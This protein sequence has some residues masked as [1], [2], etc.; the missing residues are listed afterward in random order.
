[1]INFSNYIK[2]N[3]EHDLLKEKY[4]NDEIFQIGTK[5][6]FG[7][8]VGEIIRRGPNYIIALDESNNVFRSWITDI[9]EYVE[10][11]PKRLNKYRNYNHLRDT[12]DSVQS[13]AI[14]LGM[15]PEHSYK[16]RRAVE[17]TIL[18][19]MEY[20]TA[21]NFIQ[22]ELKSN[23]LVNKAVEYYDAVLSEKQN[24]QVMAAKRQIEAAKEKV[25]KQKVDQQLQIQNQKSNQLNI[26]MR[27]KLQQQAKK[28]ASME[29]EQELDEL[30]ITGNLQS[31]QKPGKRAK[32][33]ELLKK[34]KGDTSKP[35][36][37]WF[38]E[39]DEDLDENSLVNLRADKKRQ[40][41]PNILRTL[42]TPL[43][44]KL[45]KE[46][47][48]VSEEDPC[49]KGYT[50]VGMKDMD[51]REVPN[52]VPSKGVKKARGYKAE[53]LKGNQDRIDANKNGKIDAKDFPL[54]R[55]RKNINK[56]ETCGD[57]ASGFGANGMSKED[58]KKKTRR[59]NFSNWRDEVN[60]SDNLVEKIDM[61]N[62]IIN[63]D[64]KDCPNC[65]KRMQEFSC[66]NCDVNQ[67]RTKYR[68]ESYEL[69][70]KELT[71]KR[72]KKREEIVKGM[73]KN[74]EY[75]KGKYG[76]RWKD[77]MYATA[78][79]R[80]MANEEV[81]DLGEEQERYG[82]YDRKRG[83][84]IQTGISQQSAS[85]LRKRMIGSGRSS[86]EIVIRKVKY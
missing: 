67:L 15:L 50:Q 51:G 83:S 41:N 81:E 80:A 42:N 24:P 31:Y 27:R 1:M 59:E 19:G 33:R 3:S 9:K 28:S 74:I 77:V 47:G 2:C 32:V 39:D 10:E 55:A 13:A 68:E 29:E 62:V 6:I 17:R 43:A 85:R 73:K 60:L 30:K 82:V 38:K 11:K 45:R 7:E 12:M 66:P 69:I 56:E 5:I 61:G 79:S 64:T 20:N 86:R 36:I 18:E 63:P 58:G 53:E 52:C 40:L 4:L 8:R 21:V 23:Y 78:T 75:L 57:T 54:L 71:K 16:I 44:K 25:Q 48:L 35:S 49:W 65:G 84:W 46:R 22:E 72:K 70:E 37:G 76:S 26:D 34:V 14:F